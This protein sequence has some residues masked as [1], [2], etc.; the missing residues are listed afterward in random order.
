EGFDRSFG[1]DEGGHHLGGG[2]LDDDFG[3]V[4]PARTGD[5]PFDVVADVLGRQR[6][7]FEPDSAGGLRQDVFGAE[8]PPVAKARI[9][10][11]QVPAVLP[12][13]EPVGLDLQ[14]NA[15]GAPLRLGAGPAAGVGAVLTAGAVLAAGTVLTAGVGAVLIGGV[16]AAVDEAQPFLTVTVVDEDDDEFGI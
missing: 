13:D 4:P 7:R 8:D 12:V 16:L 2:R 9:E 10:G 14:V 11:E 6:S 5:M 3:R 15:R 1:R